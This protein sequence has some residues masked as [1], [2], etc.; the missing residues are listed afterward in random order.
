M[1]ERNMNKQSLNI[2]VLA[3]FFESVGRSIVLIRFNLDLSLTWQVFK[4]IFNGQDGK[5]W[6]WVFF[7]LEQLPVKSG[8]RE[9]LM[10]FYI[11]PPLHPQS[12]TFI[13]LQQLLDEIF[14]LIAQI[15]H[16]PFWFLLPV[17]NQI[18]EMFSLAHL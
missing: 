17:R 6:R 16:G 2:V 9:E 14:Q 11:V 8:N 3:P 5:E 10:I 1:L 4:L 15:G 13:S 7:I 12:L 18:L